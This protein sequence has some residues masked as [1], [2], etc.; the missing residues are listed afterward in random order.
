MQPSDDGAG[1]APFF[2]TMDPNAYS[3]HVQVLAGL[4][5]VG[6]V[7]LHLVWKSRCRYHGKWLDAEARLERLERDNKYLAETN[8]KW[9]RAF[10]QADGGRVTLGR[11]MREAM[12]KL[13]TFAS[14]FQATSE[15]VTRRSCHDVLSSPLPENPQDRD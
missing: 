7:T 11:Q 3:L 14:A 2:T 8:I 10:I 9:R 1:G 5:L 13:R 15:D 12:D 6:S 4:L